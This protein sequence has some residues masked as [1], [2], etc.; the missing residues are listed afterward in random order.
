MRSIHF[1]LAARATT[2]ALSRTSEGQRVHLQIV[3][4]EAGHLGF[5]EC[6]PHAVAVHHGQ[7]EHGRG[8]ERLDG[9]APADL[10]R[11]HGVEL[12]AEV[13]LHHG[14]GQRHGLGIGEPLLTDERRPH[15]G[16]DRHQVVVGQLGRV[17]E[18]AHHALPVELA[19]VEEGQVRA[20]AAARAEDPGPD[21]QALYLLRGHRSHRDL[22]IRTP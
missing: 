10:E 2:T 1:Q 7:V 6:A 19:H 12:P 18:P 5:G 22:R 3:D 9:V 15:V 11:H 14:D 20:A 21:G 4:G 16:D 17:H 13:L 8:H